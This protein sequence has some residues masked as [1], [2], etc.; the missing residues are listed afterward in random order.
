MLDATDDETNARKMTRGEW[1][2]DDKRDSRKG[3]N[4]KSANYIHHD[5]VFT[6]VVSLP[7]PSPT[8]LLPPTLLAIVDIGHGIFSK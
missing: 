1:L 5:L 6:V 8:S 7:L 4:G 2:F 3:T